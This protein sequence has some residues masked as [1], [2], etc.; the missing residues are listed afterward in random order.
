[1]GRCPGVVWRLTLRDLR[2]VVAQFIQLGADGFRGRECRLQV[3]F[4]GN[5]L[6][7]YLGRCQAGIQAVGAEVGIGLALAIDNSLDIRQEV[8]AM[9]CRALPPTQGKGIDTDHA[10]GAVVQTLA[11]GHPPPPQ[12]ARGALLPT[13]PQLFDSAGHTQAPGAALERL[14]SCDQRCLERVRQFLWHTSSMR[15]PGV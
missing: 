13:P 11:H 1:M 9:Y 8:R 6:V 3:A 14:G 7:P 12:F 5:Q 10:A 15:V 4:V 2:R